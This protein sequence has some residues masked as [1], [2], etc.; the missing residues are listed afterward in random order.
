MPKIFPSY[1]SGSFLGVPSLSHSGSVMGDTLGIPSGQIGIWLPQDCICGAIFRKDF[2]YLPTIYGGFSHVPGVACSKR[3]RIG[4]AHGHRKEQRPWHHGFTQGHVA[5]GF[6]WGPFPSEHKKKLAKKLWE[7]TWPSWLFGSLLSSVMFFF[8]K[9]KRLGSL[10]KKHRFV[11]KISLL[12]ARFQVWLVLGVPAVSSTLWFFYLPMF[13]TFFGRG[14][15]PQIR[16]NLTSD[17]SQLQGNTQASCWPLLRKT[18]LLGEGFWFRLEALNFKT[19]KILWHGWLSRGE[20]F[21]ILNDLNLSEENPMG[22]YGSHLSATTLG[23]HQHPRNQIDWIHF[24]SPNSPWY[25][26]K[27]PFVYGG[28]S[29]TFQPFSV[30]SHTTNLT[31]V[32]RHTLLVLGITCHKL[33][34]RRIPHA[35]CW[36]AWCLLFFSE[37]SNRTSCF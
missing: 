31:T 35:C 28:R 30:S 14:E 5:F 7:I 16:K 18:G 15:F 12:V 23:Y 24:G 13:Q 6:G 33:W 37:R 2:L 4:Y 21:S 20:R 36:K 11:K 22:N 34:E 3:R 26:W 1:L 17:I 9:K 19:A 27:T 25:F 10:T 29:W 8:W 32:Y